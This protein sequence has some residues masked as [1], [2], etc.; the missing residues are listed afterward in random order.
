MIEDQGHLILLLPD[1]QGGRYPTVAEGGNPSHQV[2]VGKEFIESICEF[3]P[4]LNLVQLDT[5]PHNKGCTIDVV[6]RK[7]DNEDIT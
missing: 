1:M 5:I 4:K 2:D 6:F 7:E 3:L